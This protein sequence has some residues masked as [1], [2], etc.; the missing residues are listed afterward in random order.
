MDIDQFKA[1]A[2]KLMILWAKEYR[3][4]AR[5]TN[6]ETV[7]Y[8]RGES[9][10]KKEFLEIV[11]KML[12]DQITYIT[13]MASYQIW[14]GMA[15]TKT[16]LA[17]IKRFFNMQLPRNFKRYKISYQITFEGC[18]HGQSPFVYVEMLGDIDFADSY[19]FL[20]FDIIQIQLMGK[21]QWTAKSITSIIKE[22]K[23]DFQFD[24]YFPKIIVDGAMKDVVGNSTALYLRCK[25]E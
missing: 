1:S 16:N 21:K 7:D 4:E 6:Y 18:A 15:P 3:V 13:E 9:E 2:R 8:C 23:D 12:D 19:D 14:H 17:R 10:S 25:I 11:R 24:G 20:N 22:I 5:K